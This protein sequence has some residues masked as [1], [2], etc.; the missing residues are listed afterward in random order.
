MLRISTCPVHFFYSFPDHSS[1]CP[2]PSCMKSTDHSI[3]R[4]R[5]QKGGTD[6]YLDTQYNIGTVGYQA[7][8]VVIE[9]RFNRKGD[10][11]AVHLPSQSPFGCLQ[12]TVGEQIC[13]TCTELV[14][15]I[16]GASRDID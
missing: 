11:G 15:C 7:V 12:T 10:A 5:N 3:Y 13:S 16:V 8:C 1:C 9:T 4:I 2:P 14:W 6:G